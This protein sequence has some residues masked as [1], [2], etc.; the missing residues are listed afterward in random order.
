MKKLIIVLTICASIAII[1]VS[2]SSNKKCPA[3]SHKTS[4][5]STLVNY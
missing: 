5:Q 1:L 2:C 3:Y 4:V